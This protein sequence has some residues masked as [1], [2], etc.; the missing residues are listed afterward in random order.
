MMR[1]MIEINLLPGAKKAKRSGGGGGKAFDFAALGKAISDKVKDKFLAAAIV[2]GIVAVAV[3]GLMFA[4][5]R[6]KE[7]TLKEEEQKAIAD[8]VQF[9]AVLMDRMRAQAKR[10]S[11]LTQLMIIKAIDED[12][13]IW[14]HFLEEVSRALPIYTWLRSLAITGNSQGVNPAAAIKTPPPVTP[15]PKR[16]NRRSAEVFIP[17]D[18]VKV[19]MIGRTADL[20]AFTRYMRTLEDSPFIESVQMIRTEPMVEAAKEIWQWTI[21]V[22]Y[23]RP[24]TIMLKRAAI[25]L[26]TAS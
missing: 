14:P 20:Q 19:R 9:A 8:S 23:S 12:R 13:F 1:F 3:V 4:T 21:D 11:A 2:S 6:A 24:D 15:D 5:Q 18:T 26:P 25:A 16:P 7:S 17:R 10:D 22:T